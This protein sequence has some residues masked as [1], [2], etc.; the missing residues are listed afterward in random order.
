MDYGL[1]GTGVI[2]ELGLGGPSQPPEDPVLQR[3]LPDAYRDD[4]FSPHAIARLR[5]LVSKAFTARRVAE[6]RPRIQAVTD[7]LLDAIVETAKGLER[8]EAPRAV[9]VPV[10]TDGVERAISYWRAISDYLKERNSPY[11]VIIA[12]SKETD[13]EHL[14]L[15]RSLR[16][17]GVQVDIVPRLFDVAVDAGRDH[18][19]RGRAVA[20]PGDHSGHRTQRE[21]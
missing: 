14:A 13:E 10:V 19:R 17:L 3:L 12:F 8:R 4:P 5:R 11:R 20:D 7:R 15:I 18:H 9:I 6:M 16:N 21:H 1:I 2:S